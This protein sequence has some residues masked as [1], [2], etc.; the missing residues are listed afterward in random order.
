M[1][2]KERKAYLEKL[3][4]EKKMRQAA[5]KHERTK[6]E[7]LGGMDTGDKICMDCRKTI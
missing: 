3:E 7:Y 4:E 1:D 5:C 2:E 6:K